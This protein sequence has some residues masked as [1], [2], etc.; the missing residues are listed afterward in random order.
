MSQTN[1]IENEMNRLIEKLKDFNINPAAYL[2]AKAEQMETEAD[3][4]VH[5][6]DEAPA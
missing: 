3:N 6:E 5:H 1:I 2:R 4:N